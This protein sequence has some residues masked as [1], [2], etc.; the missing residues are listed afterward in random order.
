MRRPTRWRDWIVIPALLLV[1]I[2]VYSQFEGRL[3][4][5]P[6]LWVALGLLFAAR[7]LERS[8]RTVELP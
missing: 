2:V 4:E 5:E 7:R 6:Y 8:L 1:P 3:V